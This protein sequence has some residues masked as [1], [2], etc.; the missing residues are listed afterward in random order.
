MYWGPAEIPI[1]HFIGLAQILR[2]E[3]ST[4]QKAIL[5]MMPPSRRKGL[6][7]SSGQDLYG[8]LVRFIDAE[9]SKNHDKIYALLGMCTMGK[10]HGPLT[11]DYS[12]SLESL[13]PEAVAYMS[14]CDQ[15]DVPDGLNTME[16]LGE[17]L[18]SLFQGLLVHFAAKSKLFSLRALLLNRGDHI[19][20]T[21][22]IIEKTVQDHK[23]K[24]VLSILLSHPIDTVSVS[25]NAVEEAIAQWNHEATELLLFQLEKETSCMGKWIRATLSMIDVDH[26]DCFPQYTPL[27]LAVMIGEAEDVRQLLEEGADVDS[28][29]QWPSTLPVRERDDSSR[30]SRI[31][32]SI[33]AKRQQSPSLPP[34]LGI[35]SDAANT[36]DTHFRFRTALAL[37]VHHGRQ[38]VVQILLDHGAKIEM[39]CKDG[40]TP[41]SIAAGG[42]F[43]GIASLGRS[44][45]G[46]QI[47]RRTIGGPY[48]EAGSPTSKTDKVYSALVQLL[49]DRG[50]EVNS[51]DKS[52]RSPLWWAVNHGH[53][54]AVEKLL[55][56]KAVMENVN[57]REMS[58]LS[59]AIWNGYEDITAQLLA[60]D[61]QRIII[62]HD[63]LEWAIR[64]GNNPLL[65]E[66]IDRCAL[67]YG[68]PFY[69]IGSPL[70]VAIEEG[71]ADALQ[72]LAQHR[73]LLRGS[74]TMSEGLLLA[75]S[76]GDIRCVEILL[77]AGS[78]TN[79]A[80]FDG[81]TPLSRAIAHGNREMVQRLLEKSCSPNGSDRHQYT[82]LL[83]AIRAG[84]FDIAQD[85]LESHAQVNARCKFAETALGEAAL[86]G[87]QDMVRL[88]LQHGAVVDICNDRGTTPLM[89]ACDRGHTA[90]VEVL[91]DANADLS[92]RDEDGRTALD[93]AKHEDRGRI[94]QILT[95]HEEFLSKKKNSELR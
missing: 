4:H 91:L 38:N 25:L 15:S 28:P 74:S 72:T 41:L 49:L 78:N 31:S 71:N 65:R 85:L 24:E 11:I 57:S 69:T 88:L 79:Y 75:A 95:A 90:V 3:M 64:A 58:L 94:V 19:T 73:M 61:A 30:D 9:A 5:D 35:C 8:L 84:Y 93:W 50:A 45:H 43:D 26:P 62:T 54:S 46:A 83:I 22:Q 17:G 29:L 40:R 51:A 86:Q 48:L 81:N 59:W 27:G 52:Y 89:W 56:N 53:Q 33:W 60:N 6:A 21:P 7:V 67:M 39:Q 87:H 55:E 44:T 77:E 14:F 12:K 23:G 92:I 32:W 10:G 18:E 37:A 80:D 68:E 1:R 36:R 63:Y 47:V 42:G 34:L 82:P 2:V 13:I 66:L 70:A 76:K 16:S 20:I